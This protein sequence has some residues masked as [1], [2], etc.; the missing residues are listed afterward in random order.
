MFAQLARGHQFTKLDLAQAYL[1]LPVLENSKE[2]VVKMKSIAC[3]L[4][5]RPA[6]D[7]DLKSSAVFDI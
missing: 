4:V 1:Q 5:W 3:S 7:K 2:L 6:I